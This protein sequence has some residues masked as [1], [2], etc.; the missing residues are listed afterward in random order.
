MVFEN[1]IRTT[2]FTLLTLVAAVLVAAVGFVS[3]TGRGQAEP[4]PYTSVTLTATVSGSSVTAS[5][6]ITGWTGGPLQ[7][8]GVCVRDGQDNNHDFAPEAD[9]D[10]S[11]PSI[12]FSGTQKL[13]YGTYTYSTCVE[14]ADSNWLT[15]GAPKTFTVAVVPVQNPGALQRWH[16]A[17][18]DRASKPARW[19]AIGE[20]LTEGQ[21][22]SSRS[23]RFLDLTRDRLRA[24]YPVSRVS[25]GENYI[26]AVYRVWGP[27]STWTQPYSASTGTLTPSFWAASLGYRSLQIGA[28]ASVTYPVTGSSA[29]IW[30]LN[31][32]ITGTLTYRVDGGSAHSVNTAGSSWTN[33]RILDVPLGAAGNHTITVSAQSSWVLLAGF[34]VYNGDR[35]AGI[36][37][38]DSS[39][40]GAEVSTFLAGLATFH[41]AAADVAPDLVT[42]ELGGND[43]LNGTDPAEFGAELAGLVQDLLSLPKIPSI[44]L[45]V[46]YRT[47][48]PALANPIP[49]Q[50]YADQIHGVAAAYPAQVSVIDFAQLMP[51]T[52]SSGDG[53]YSTDAIHP[54]DRGQRV[55]ADILST[56]L[57]S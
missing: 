15:L 10:I 14:T 21:G 4:A 29:D 38:Y 26:P 54:N 23:L 57:G 18:A 19:L 32:P 53:Y 30:Y 16:K 17:L 41:Q 46:P 48:P 7:F 47:N 34:T 22:A 2:R 55:M 50:D 40:S 28:G 9:P 27:D 12:R 8:V 37:V 42:I 39:Y 1:G 49:Y 56:G 13:G 24:K 52:D 6:V 33:D 11:Q 35:T 3:C 25:G 43:Y 20:S 31:G 44:V 5:T 45:L 36:Q 51:A